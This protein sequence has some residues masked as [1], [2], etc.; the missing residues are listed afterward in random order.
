MMFPIYDYT[1]PTQSCGLGATHTGSQ[2]KTAKVAAGTRLG[3]RAYRSYLKEDE[4]LSRP[5][6]Q[7]Y[8]HIIP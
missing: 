3:M 2:T 5:V 1:S 6:S 7:S 8:S 4:D